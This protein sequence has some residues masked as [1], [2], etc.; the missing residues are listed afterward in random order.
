MI[1]PEVKQGLRRWQEVLVGAAVAALGLYWA[2]FTGGGVL[3]WIGWL[4]CAVGCGLGVAGVQRA[5]FR[6]GSD[7][8]GVVQVIERRVSYFGPLNGGLVDLEAMTSLLLDPT[9]KPPHWVMRVPGQEPLHIPLTAKGAD[10]LFDAFASLPGIQT[11]HMLRQMHGDP[12][13]PV[14]IWRTPAAQDAPI[15]LH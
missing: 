7:G 1:R 6:Q 12:V 8:P 15:R 9:E 5:R 2:L 3:H 4:V 11:E 13:G 10:Q 14:V